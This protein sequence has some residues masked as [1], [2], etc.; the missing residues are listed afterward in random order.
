MRL[1]SFLFASAFAI[2]AISSSEAETLFTSDQ[3]EVSS[4]VLLGDRACVLTYTGTK[5]DTTAIAIKG[6]YSISFNYP[7]WN[8][9][10]RLAPAALTTG[11][12]L[13]AQGGGFVATGIVIFDP[14]SAFEGD[15][16]YLEVG[17]Q[18]VPEDLTEMSKSKQVASLIDG[19]GKILLKWSLKNSQ[20]PLK[21]W[22]DCVDRL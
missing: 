17:W 21:A 4:E 10:K 11:E 3:W 12:V 9:R 5:F 7:N 22:S 8:F 6:N 15:K 20:K 16:V 2:L 18:D 1:S 14:H 13:P 19:N